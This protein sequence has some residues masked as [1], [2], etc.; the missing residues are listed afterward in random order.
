MSLE[1]KI[2]E[3]KKTVVIRKH[4]SDEVLAQV[5]RGNKFVVVKDSFDLSYVPEGY[6]LI[7][8]KYKGDSFKTLVPQS[9]LFYIANPGEGNSNDALDDIADFYG[10][11]EGFEDDMI[12]NGQTSVQETNWA[13]LARSSYETYLINKLVKNKKG[14][15]DEKGEPIPEFNSKMLHQLDLNDPYVE[16]RLKAI[17]VIALGKSA[18]EVKKYDI[19][20][21]LKHITVREDKTEQLTREEFK[22]ITCYSGSHYELKAEY[23]NKDDVE[24]SIGYNY[25][26]SRMSGE[27]RTKGKKY[28]V[29][30]SKIRGL[31]QEIQEY[32]K[33]KHKGPLGK[34]DKA[35]L[36]QY[37][38][39][40]Y[41]AP[42]KPKA[43]LD[44]APPKKKRKNE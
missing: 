34:H 35:L 24:Y 10:E 37:A 44:L 8:I 4:P 20:D 25:G 26:R 2:E 39:L 30:D 5:E 36:R 42:D 40:A 11:V 22:K 31:E 19:A 21:V 15:S 41:I 38:N 27:K 23:R 33:N 7:N 13:T 1:R 17:A 12:G 28:H 32:R 16:Q 6:T 43:Q 29:L 18:E 14:K 9:L 3:K